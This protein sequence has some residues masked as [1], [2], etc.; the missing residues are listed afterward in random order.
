MTTEDA[1]KIVDIGNLSF[2]QED[3]GFGD[4]SVSVR[5]AKVFDTKEEADLFL[6]ALKFLCQ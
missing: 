2:D 6:E 4:G 3:A 1:K 5:P